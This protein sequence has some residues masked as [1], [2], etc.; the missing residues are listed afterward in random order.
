MRRRYSADP[1]H[2][3]NNLLAAATNMDA[4]SAGFFIFWILWNVSDEMIAPL[5]STLRLLLNLD[6]IVNA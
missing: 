5:P 1:D 2:K 4:T 6:R 3:N